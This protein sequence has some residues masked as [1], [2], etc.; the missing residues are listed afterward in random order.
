M[1]HTRYTST[2]I[3]IFAIGGA[4]QAMAQ[5]PDMDVPSKPDLS[6]AALIEDP[7]ADPYTLSYRPERP[8]GV[9]DITSEA[10]CTAAG[11]RW[12]TL[13]CHPEV[14]QCDVGCKIQNKIQGLVYTRPK[15]S[16]HSRGQASQGPDLGYTWYGDGQKQGWSSTLA[17]PIDDT[18]LGPTT[19]LVHYQDDQ[20]DGAAFE[21]SDSGE[22][23]RVATY[24]QGQ[25]DGKIEE[26]QEC[27]PTIL[28]QYRKGL[29]VGTWEFYLEPG[30]ISH[31]VD[32]DRKAPPDLDSGQTYWTEGFNGDGIKIV[33]GYATF[34]D[35]TQI[36]G[37]FFRVG[38][39]QL[40]STK[41]MSWIKVHYA[42]EG[43]IDDQPSFKLCQSEASGDTIPAFI[44]YDHESLTMM[45]Q[46]AAHELIQNVRYYTDGKLWMISPVDD[47]G[48]PHGIVREYHPTGELLA[49]IAYLHGIPEG[50][51]VYYDVNGGVIGESTIIHGN[52]KWTAYWHNGK[53]RE[54]GEFLN[55]APSGT[56]TSWYESGLRQSETNFKNG[57]EN[58]MYREW[59]SNGVLSYEVPYEN[60]Q[61]EGKLD[62]YYVD[63]RLGYTYHFSHGLFDKLHTDYM[64]SGGIQVKTDYSNRMDI[65]QVRF[66][67]D[68]NKRAEGGVSQFSKD[69]KIGR[70]THYLKDGASW[71]TLD[72]DEN[73]AIQGAEAESC[74]EFGGTYKIDDENRQLGCAVCRV[75]RKSP[76]TPR[77]VRH[78]KWTWWNEK[79][80]VETHGEYRL[81]H[82]QGEWNYYHTNG[83]PMI[84][85]TYDIDRKV[86]RW[87]GFYEDGTPKFDG[88]YLDGVENGPWKTFHPNTGTVASSG[89]FVQG[90]RHGTWKYFTEDEKLRESGDFDHGKETGTWTSFYPNG[91][92][93]GQGD[94]VD[95]MRQGKWTWFRED[96]SLWRTATYEKGKEIR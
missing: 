29:P 10:L 22:L 88:S 62:G 51:I 12:E 21:W 80:S 7:P 32:F 72:Y 39:Q 89:N 5:L 52:G 47:E 71:L 82:L 24:A 48:R 59:Y 58:G 64:H 38:D 44:R 67:P 27:L 35:P 84:S 15:P 74:R 9:P 91:A 18:H 30:L 73:G 54:S 34:T 57:V 56:W 1:K 25:L 20:R 43:H 33:E 45:C 31:R 23:L 41:G 37:E 49:S 14:A 85:G 28:G 42:K 75:N 19:A 17:D 69:F 93:Q 65:R 83:K 63:G 96:G 55:G 77:Y 6:N 87:Q 53:P 79:G 90:K 13:E 46:N 78:G 92:I 66:Y 60:G 2:M 50:V 40:F 81:G 3:L 94:F 8:E 61:Y 68:G 11:G 4:S 95:G 76:R 36:D 26:Y 16:P 86:G 70:W